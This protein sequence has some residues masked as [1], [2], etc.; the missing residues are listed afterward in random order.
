[1]CLGV[2]LSLTTFELERCIHNL[3]YSLG[4]VLSLTT[5][6]LASYRTTG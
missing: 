1:M 2:V 6:E 3:S 5:F 4:V